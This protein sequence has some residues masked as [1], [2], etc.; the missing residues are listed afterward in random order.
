[1]YPSFSPSS[2]WITGTALNSSFMIRVISDWL[3]IGK[4][5]EGDAKEGSFP[6]IIK[7][8]LDER[9]NKALMEGVQAKEKPL[10]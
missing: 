1:M 7:Q 10:P 5:E 3:K 2:G 4:M 6:E 8:K 9:Q